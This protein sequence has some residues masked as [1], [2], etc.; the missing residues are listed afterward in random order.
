MICASSRAVRRNEFMFTG[1]IQSIGTVSAVA[2]R[3]GDL[4]LT[5]EASG[6]DLGR[7]Q[8]GDSVAVA[9]CCLTVAERTPR[10][11]IADVSA[12]TLAATTLGNWRVGTRI[13]LEAALRVGDALGGHLVSGH[14]DGRAEVLDVSPEGGSQRLR[15]RA[16]ASLQR[17]LARKGSVTLDG[18][19][20]TVNE[21]EGRDFT[22][23]LIPHT[24]AVT[25]L[26]GLARRAQLNLE[27]DIM[28]RYA[29]RL[30]APTAD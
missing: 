6:L 4:R 17:Y 3:G 27:I 21:V 19:S 24:L 28:A 25:T 15:C 22:V 20:I 7:L 2:P 8:L 26:G 13:N 14:V 9:G 18:V 12:A 5:V 23:N 10:G 29:E 16:P 11:F 1:I 30:L